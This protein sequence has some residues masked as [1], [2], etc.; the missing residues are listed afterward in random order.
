MSDI[1]A[2]V[3]ARL[4]EEE[5][6]AKGPPGWKPEHWTA[7]NYAARPSGRNYRVDAEP[8]CVADQVAREDAE[9]IAA[10]DP[11]RVLREVAAKRKILAECDEW[12]M[13]HAPSGAHRIL[14]AVAAVYSDHPDYDPNLIEE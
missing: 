7:V 5:A 3:R 1:V 12:M 2:F 10:H 4:D 6:A 8:R 9:F 14:R 13:Q 11:A